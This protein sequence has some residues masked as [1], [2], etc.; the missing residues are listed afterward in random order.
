MLHSDVPPPL[1]GYPTNSHIPPPAILQ[2]SGGGGAESDIYYS[3]PSEVVE[4]RQQRVL[5]KDGVFVSRDVRSPQGSADGSD[6]GIRP[7]LG[8]GERDTC[9]VPSPFKHA[10]LYTEQWQALL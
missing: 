1:G 5:T 6:H 10:V 2:N 3:T 4:K 7:K 9:I 8:E